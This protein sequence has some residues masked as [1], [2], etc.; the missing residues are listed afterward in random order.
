MIEELIED[1]TQELYYHKIDMAIKNLEA[2]AYYI[3][4]IID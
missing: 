3:S 2:A 1:S 4:K